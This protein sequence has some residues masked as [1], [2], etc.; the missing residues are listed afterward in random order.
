M[1]ARLLE[2]RSHRVAKVQRVLFPEVVPFPSQTRAL[3]D[4]LQGMLCIPSMFWVVFVCSM[5]ERGLDAGEH[6]ARKQKVL[7]R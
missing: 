5:L 2:F 6:L 3:M 1:A 4:P 7:S